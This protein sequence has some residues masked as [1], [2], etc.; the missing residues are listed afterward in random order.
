MIIYELIR[1]FSYWKKKYFKI[2]L[3]CYIYVYI[4]NIYFFLFIV[5]VLV[6]FECEVLEKSFEKE[7]YK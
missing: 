3:C 4:L 6:L 1:F 2:F 7:K 5:L